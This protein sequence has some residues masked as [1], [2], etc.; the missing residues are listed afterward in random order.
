[1]N[2][3]MGGPSPNGRQTKTTCAYSV[4]STVRQ[5]TPSTK[6]GELQP[7]SGARLLQ[8][9]ASRV[10]GHEIARGGAHVFE[11]KPARYQR[12]LHA[13]RAASP[14]PAAG[15]AICQPKAPVANRNY[16]AC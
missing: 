12:L 16:Q 4:G 14:E 13:Y 3:M 6:G 15:P 11:A 10:A 1:M 9:I 5:S 7:Q 8:P 2:T